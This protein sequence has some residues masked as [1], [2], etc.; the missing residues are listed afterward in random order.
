MRS[1]GL[2][3]LFRKDVQRATIA[4]DAGNLLNRVHCELR[5]DRVAHFPRVRRSQRLPYGSRRG[6]SRNLLPHDFMR[7]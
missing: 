2:N 1:S 5:H 4:D 6:P 3:H 7:S